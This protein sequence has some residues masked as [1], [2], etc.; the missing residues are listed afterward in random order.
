MLPLPSAEET[1]YLNHQT[2]SSKFRRTASYQNILFDRCQG[3]ASSSTNSKNDFVFPM[4]RRR[5]QN[6]LIPSQTSPN[7]SI[8]L[9][10]AVKRCA[11]PNPFPSLS[12]NQSWLEKQNKK[13]QKKKFMRTKLNKPRL[14]TPFQNGPNGLETGFCSLLLPDLL[15]SQLLL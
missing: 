10:S 3:L 2:G 4:E 8:Y 9:S 14:Q 12:I 15:L 5:Q 13:Q 7:R 1:D 11:N 6:V